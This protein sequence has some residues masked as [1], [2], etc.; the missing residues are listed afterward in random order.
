M[1]EVKAD[2][3]VLE[4]TSQAFPEQYDAWVGGAR[5]AYLRLRGG[6]FY[7]QCP[8]CALFDGVI[9]YA[10]NVGYGEFDTAEQR[11]EELGKAREAIA[12]WVNETPGWRD[13]VE[14]MYMH[15]EVMVQEAH[16]DLQ[17]WRCRPDEQP[18][19]AKRIDAQRE[20]KYRAALQL[21]AA[22]TTVEW[23]AKRRGGGGDAK[24]R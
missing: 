5:V 9:V 3:V 22:N 2:D 17:H 13:P 18:A 6:H 1:G 11:V 8:T 19:W 15:H 7:V 24:Q 4:Q 20:A 21:Q 23:L 12:K 14:R 16:S 10:A